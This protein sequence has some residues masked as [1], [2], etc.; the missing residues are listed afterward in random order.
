MY[1]FV[2]DFSN[3]RMVYGTDNFLNIKHYPE[4][5]KAQKD[6]LDFLNV[7]IWMLLLK[8]ACIISYLLFVLEDQINKTQ[9]TICNFLNDFLDFGSFQGAIFI[10]ENLS[11]DFIIFQ[12]SI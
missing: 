4:E 9:T 1:D 5:R 7:G 8:V 3:L 10:F 6:I 12:D 11:Q 2:D